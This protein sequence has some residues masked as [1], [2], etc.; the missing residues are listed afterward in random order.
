MSRVSFVTPLVTS[1]TSFVGI[2][3]TNPEEISDF[4]RYKDFADGRKITMALSATMS[5][6]KFKKEKHDDRSKFAQ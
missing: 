2:S 5:E 3:P 4:S 6:S 1:V